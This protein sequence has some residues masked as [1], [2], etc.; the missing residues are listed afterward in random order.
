MRR[1]PLRPSARTVADICS[2]SGVFRAAAALFASN[3]SRFWLRY[4]RRLL[5][6]APL[7]RRLEANVGPVGE[8]WW[9]GH[10]ARRFRCQDD[11]V[12]ACHMVLDMPPKLLRDLLRLGKIDPLVTKA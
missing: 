3:A 9:N 8:L 2:G 4:S 6:V 12:R 11:F 10:H 1:M 7:L 5:M